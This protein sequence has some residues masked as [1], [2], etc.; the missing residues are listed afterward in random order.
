MMENQPRTLREL[1]EAG[2]PTS[3][4]RIFLHTEHAEYTYADVHSHVEHVA[5]LFSRSGVGPGDRVVLVVDKSP[6]AL[7]FSLACLHLGVVLVPANPAYTDHEANYLIDDSKPELVICSHSR[8]G[9]LSN[10]RHLTLKADGRGSLT[11][12]L[13]SLGGIAIGHRAQPDDVAAVVYTS[14]TTGRPKGAMLTNENLA[15]NAAALADLWGFNNGDTV[16]HALPIYHVHGLFVAMNTALASGASL[17]FLPR[18]DP[19]SVIDAFEQS[20]VFMG[21]PT[22]YTRLLEQTRLD[23]ST[24]RHMRLFVSGSAPLLA[25]THEEF[26]RRTGHEILERYGMTELSM[27]ASNPLRGVRKPGTV[28]P[29]LPGV[30]VRL[31]EESPRGSG[32]SKCTVRMS[33][34]ATGTVHRSGLPKS[35]RTATSEPVTSARSTAMAIYS[36]VGRQK[37]LV[38]SGGMNV[39]PSEIESVLDDLDGVNESAVV[40]VPDPDFGEIAI[41]IIVASKGVVLAEDAIRAAARSRLASFKIPKHVFVVAELPRNAM[42]KVKRPRCRALRRS[43]GQRAVQRLTKVRAT[44]GSDAGETA[45]ALDRARGGRQWMATALTIREKT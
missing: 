14:G 25:R 4:D 45:R 3:D 15:S 41:A 8:I 1:Y 30:R 10:E 35:R 44:P 43:A 17:L 39:Y 28:G 33:F 24:C 11:T 22:H 13:E 27:I 2:R 9:G 37:D 31:H 38:I 36:I 19:H 26:A 6:A 34:A 42:G 32:K 18:F 29:A 5:E 16:A 21:V 23:S 20:T 40:G 12:A 7:L